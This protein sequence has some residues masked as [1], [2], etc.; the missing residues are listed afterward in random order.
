MAQF[1]QDRETYGTGLLVTDIATEKGALDDQK[2]LAA[3]KKE[4]WDTEKATLDGFET[5][6]NAAKEAWQNRDQSQD[7]QQVNNDL[8]TAKT[9]A[10]TAFDDQK[11]ISDAKE[12]EY[13][14]EFGKIQALQ[15]T[16]DTELGKQQEK[17]DQG[18]IDRVEKKLWGVEAQDEVQ[19]DPDNG[20]AYSP[21][22]EKVVG[23]EEQV[24]KADK[25]LSDAYNAKGAAEQ[26]V[27][28][29]QDPQNVYDLVQALKDANAE[30][31][32]KEKALNRL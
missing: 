13:D 15:D 14:T 32:Q 26:A 19:A 27:S 8:Q 29:N 11:V 1:L 24:R 16:Y 2:A 9:N 6:L 22:V 23:I 25:E 30:V 28:K 17:Y 4:A 5:T 3:Q 31:Y 10:Q 20:I 21:A 12:G 18:I 7:G